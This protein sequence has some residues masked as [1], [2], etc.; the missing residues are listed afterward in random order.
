MHVCIRELLYLGVVV[1][2]KLE[3]SRKTT[4][5]N[6]KLFGKRQEF[7]VETVAKSSPKLVTM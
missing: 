3:T 4:K 6:V 5:K 1:E 7:L 2:S